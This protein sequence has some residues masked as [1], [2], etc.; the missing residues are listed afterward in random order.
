[1]AAAMRGAAAQQRRGPEQKPPLGSPE[2]VRRGTA[3]A[4]C[5][6]AGGA[7]ASVCRDRVAVIG[8][9]LIAGRR[10][11][12]GAGHRPR[13][14]RLVSAR[15]TAAVDRRF[16]AAR[17]SADDGAPRRAPARSPRPTS[18]APP[19]CSKDQPHPAI[20]LDA[21]RAPVEQV[22]WVKSAQRRSGCCPTRSSSPSTQRHC[23]RSGSTTAAPA[24]STA[25]GRVA[26]EADPGQFTDLPLVVGE[27]ADQA[28]AGHPAGCSQTPRRSWRSGS[29]PWSASTTGAGTC[30]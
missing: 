17:L 12:A 18:C 24:S 15:Q 21:V 9:G 11:V 13:G 23:W 16:A 20:D 4:A 14:E 27:G 7:S 28:A 6:A 3:P 26:P 1:M 19:R 8:A 10:L 30:G 5:Q 29:T 25:T 2:P 22:G